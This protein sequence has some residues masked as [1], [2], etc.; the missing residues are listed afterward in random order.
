MPHN[1]LSDNCHYEKQEFSNY[2]GTGQLS[3]LEW[4]AGLRNCYLAHLKFD[5]VALLH[6]SGHIDSSPVS[7]IFGY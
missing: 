5:L 4:L 6:V 7:G 1:E 3:S 2:S